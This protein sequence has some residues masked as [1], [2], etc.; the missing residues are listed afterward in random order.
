MTDPLMQADATVVIVDPAAELEIKTHPVAP[1]LNSLRGTRIA[2]IDNT[3]HMANRFLDATRVL[4]EER[5]HVGGFEYYRKTSAS[6][7]TPPDVLNRL[8]AS[9]DAVIHGV[10]D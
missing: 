7:P 9:C 4:L 8:T 2:V 10:A 6:V 5:Y 1:R 3:K